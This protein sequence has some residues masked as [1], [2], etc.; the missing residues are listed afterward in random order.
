M[1]NVT[2]QND[3]LKDRVAVVTGGISN[4]GLGTAT[5]FYL[6]ELGAKVYALGD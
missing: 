2:Y 5:A 3:I 6:A 1:A 4:G